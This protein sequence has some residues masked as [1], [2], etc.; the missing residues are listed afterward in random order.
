MCCDDK[1]YSVT[2]AFPYCKGNQIPGEIDF[3]NSSASQQE[4]GF[5]GNYSDQVDNIFFRK[6]NINVRTLGNLPDGEKIG[7]KGG[8]L[9]E[10]RD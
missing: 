5:T 10:D 1:Y 9:G 4:R 8:M 3:E 2:N 6:C 7:V